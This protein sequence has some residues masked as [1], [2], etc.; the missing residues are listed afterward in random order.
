MA[1]AGKMWDSTV[2]VDADAASEKVEAQHK[3]L[4]SAVNDLCKRVLGMDVDKKNTREIC[5]DSFFD[6]C[7]QYVLLELIVNARY[8]LYD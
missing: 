7:S 8:S 1:Y 3:K 4:C 6:N 5:E 2:D